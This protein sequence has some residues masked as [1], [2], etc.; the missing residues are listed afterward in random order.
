MYIHI[1]YTHYNRQTIIL[2][3]ALNMWMVS[4]DHIK[5]FLD[6]YKRPKM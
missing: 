5:I 4:H 3:F 6:T 2:Q 1:L